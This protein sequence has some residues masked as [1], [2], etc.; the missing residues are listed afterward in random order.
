MDTNSHVETGSQNISDFNSESDSRE[1]Y[2][3][4]SQ[5]ISCSQEGSNIEVNTNLDNSNN[6]ITLVDDENN[7][8]LEHVDNNIQP[9]DSQMAMMNGNPYI[10]C[11]TN[12]SF[13]SDSQ[14]S[15][16][17]TNH[18]N[19]YKN[20]LIAKTSESYFEEYASNFKKFNDIKSFQYKAEKKFEEESVIEIFR[21]ISSDIQSL[22]VMTQAKSY[23]AGINYNEISLQE[24][25]DET[26][27]IYEKLDKI[28][29]NM[30]TVDK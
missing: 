18:S 23:H 12:S 27:L 6:N 10:L 20:E 21:E 7:L 15:Q 16:L 22:K 26:K 25:N 13:E 2:Q 1:F 19:L 14:E 24:T 17:V 28:Q 29:S 8:Q 5:T 9:S 4:D 3:S 30:F 11:Q